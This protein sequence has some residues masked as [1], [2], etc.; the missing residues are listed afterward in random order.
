MAHRQLD[1]WL[2]ARRLEASSVAAYLG[3]IHEA[4]RAPATAAMVVAAVKRP[5]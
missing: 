1:A 5:T 4:G 2:G 3:H